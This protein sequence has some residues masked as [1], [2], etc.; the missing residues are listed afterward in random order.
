MFLCKEGKVLTWTACSPLNIFGLE[1][2]VLHN[3]HL[4]PRGEKNLCFYIQVSVVLFPS[5]S[6]AKVQNSQ[7]ENKQISESLD[8]C[9]NTVREPLEAGHFSQEQV[10]VFLYV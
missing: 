7:R 5:R 10:V 4:K 3:L 6:C 2:G 1:R 8:C 9:Q